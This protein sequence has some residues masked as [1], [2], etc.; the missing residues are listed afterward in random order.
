MNVKVQE[1]FTKEKKKKT[2]LPQITRMEILCPFHQTTKEYRKH[3]KQRIKYDR[4]CCY[5]KLINDRWYDSNPGFVDVS[6][7]AQPKCLIP[8]K[9]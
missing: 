2:H 8:L 9:P 5:R 4:P 3:F 7:T 1:R 6:I